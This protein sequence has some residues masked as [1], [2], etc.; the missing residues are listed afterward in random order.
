MNDE[1]HLRYLASLVSVFQVI[2]VPYPFP[3]GQVML[4][5]KLSNLG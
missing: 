5:P 1:I 2:M 3:S 4:L